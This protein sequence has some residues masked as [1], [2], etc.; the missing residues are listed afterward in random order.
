MDL[1]RTE[2]GNK[3]IVFQD[4][5]TKWPNLKAIRVAHL[6]VEE[7]IPMFGVAEALLSDRGT[8]LL[9]RN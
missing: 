4:L 7:I 2:N 9:S 3:H 1:P 5:L 8:N 6:I